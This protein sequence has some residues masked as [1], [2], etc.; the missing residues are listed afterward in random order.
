MLVKSS[1]RTRILAVR[2]AKKSVIRLGLM[3]AITVRPASSTRPF[4]TLDDLV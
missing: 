4:L 1:Q 3:G 2:E